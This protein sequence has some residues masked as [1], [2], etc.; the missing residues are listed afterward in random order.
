MNT[1]LL[2]ALVF[3]AFANGEEIKNF[4]M[5]PGT[6]CKISSLDVNPCPQSLKGKMCEFSTG[7]NVSVNFSYITEFSSMVPKTNWYAVVGSLEVP[8]PNMK[9]DGCLYTSCPIKAGIE[10]KYYTG[11]IPLIKAIP[12]G[13]YVG[14]IKFWDGTKFASRKD[15]CCFR[16]TIKIN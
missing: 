9:T 8:N 12:K 14:Q 15:H 16:L 10:G 11:E 6:R 7:L 13:Q 3:L 1:L 5:C 4:E 2:S